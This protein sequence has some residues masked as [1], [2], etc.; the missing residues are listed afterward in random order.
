MKKVMLGLVMVMMLMSMVGCGIT[1]KNEESE[2]TT[3][4]NTDVIEITPNTEKD[5]TVSRVVLIENYEVV[6]TENYEGKLLEAPAKVNRIISKKN[7]ADGCGYLEIEIDL[8]SVNMG[9]VIEGFKLTELPDGIP[10]EAGFEFRAVVGVEPNGY[11][12]VE[13]VFE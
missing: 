3:E 1:E 2:V 13:L 5:L 7:T 11:S 4:M 6:K 12:V 10:A 8:T 9:H